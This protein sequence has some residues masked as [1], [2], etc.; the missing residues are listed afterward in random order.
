MLTRSSTIIDAHPDRENALAEFKRG[1]EAICRIVSDQRLT[2]LRNFIVQF[3]AE[4]VQAVAKE[5]EARYTDYIDLMY[6]EASN[7]LEEGTGEFRGQE[8]LDIMSEVFGFVV[9]ES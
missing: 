2:T 7:I 8:D 6:S 5:V 3:K 1:V 9:K 4:W